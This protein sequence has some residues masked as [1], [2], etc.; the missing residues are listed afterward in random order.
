MIAD[1]PLLFRILCKKIEIIIII[2]GRMMYEGNSALDV[3]F[4]F[5]LGR[6]NGGGVADVSTMTTIL[7]KFSSKSLRVVSWKRW[8]EFGPL[9]PSYSRFDTLSTEIKNQFKLKCGEIDRGKKTNLTDPVDV[10]H[11]FSAFV[12]ILN[13]QTGFDKLFIALAQTPHMQ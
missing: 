11:Q 6:A 2:D 7:S 3:S 12:H 1:R 9:W 8:C 4:N 13:T 10:G 5:G